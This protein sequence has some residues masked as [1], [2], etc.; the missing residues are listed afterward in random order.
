[1]NGEASF[2][3]T[4]RLAWPAG[5]LAALGLFGCNGKGVGGSCADVTACGGDPSGDWKIVSACQFDNSQPK[6]PNDSVTS[7]YTAPQSPALAPPA[8]S[9]GSSGDWCQALSFIT[10]SDGTASSLLLRLNSEPVAYVLGG[11]VSAASEAATPVP[12]GAVL[13]VENH[14]AVHFSPT[15]LGAHGVPPTCSALTAF[16]AGGAFLNYND[17]VCDNAGDGGCDCSYLYYEGTTESAYYQ[18]VGSQLVIVNSASRL[19]PRTYDYCVQ[20]DTMTM[21]GH[22]GI[23]LFGSKNL[24]WVE[25][26]RCL[27]AG[28]TGS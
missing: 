16:A 27:T 21:G 10:P 13:S 17:F 12:F 6:N 20:G 28:C 25:L 22:N 4:A 5:L 7:R 19:P 3:K 24:R 9:S 14:F 2:K 18:I 11:V 8:T 1:M 26:T 23:G 15:C